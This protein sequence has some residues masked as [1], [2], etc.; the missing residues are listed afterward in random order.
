MR[1]ILFL[2]AVG[3]VALLSCKAP[4]KLPVNQV[5]QG[6]FGSVAEAVG[7]QMPRVGQATPEPVPY[8]TTVFFYEPTNIRQANQVESAPLFTAI[9]TRLVA[10]VQTDSA[11]TFVQPLPVGTYSVFVQVGQQFFANQFDIRNNI[12]L[13]TVEPGKLTE[14]K[15]VVNHNAAY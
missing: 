2:A 6:I 7:N 13:V 9:F 8:P 12:S 4:Q 5:K 10:T 15:I 3:W 11:G 1:L 14:I